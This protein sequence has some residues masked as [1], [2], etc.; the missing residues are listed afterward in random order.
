MNLILDES[1]QYANPISI[2][3]IKFQPSWP[4]YQSHKQASLLVGRECTEFQE[5]QAY[6]Y[7]D[8]TIISRGVQRGMYTV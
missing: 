6:T 7:L 5:K 3:K 1:E 2:R 8:A 4:S